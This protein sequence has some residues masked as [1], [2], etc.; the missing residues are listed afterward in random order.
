MSVFTRVESS[1]SA[2]EELLG[3]SIT[4][5]DNRGIFHDGGGRPLFSLE[6]Q[7]HQKN[8]VCKVGFSNRCVA[9]C[10]Y[11][12]IQKAEESVGEYFFHHCWKGVVEIVAPLKKGDMLL[13][14]LYIGI[15]R[16]VG[17][18][19]P[20][21]ANLLQVAAEKEY[22]RLEEFD[23]ERANTIGR[24]LSVLSKGIVADVEDALLL[25]DRAQSREGVIREYVFRR[26]SGSPSL[27]ALA[28]ELHL[29]PSRTS[30]LV[31]KLCGKS[32]EELVVEERMNRA[33]NLL[34]T[35]ELRIGQIAELAGFPDQFS[36]NKPFRR[37]QGCSPGGL[38]RT[39]DLVRGTS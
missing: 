33:M 37:R 20:D 39:R 5:V 26:A 8:Q 3:V 34:R 11:A 24:M 17:Q 10:R 18:S 4:L 19:C 6:R 27:P 35:T 38:R 13:G 22:V 21:N 36:F 31:K 29:S 30:H 7:S 15:W 12:M 14:L 16:P 2:F 32:F 9:H 28:G 23:G 25:R 1:L